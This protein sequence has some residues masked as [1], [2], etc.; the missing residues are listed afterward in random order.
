MKCSIF[1]C[2]QVKL[3]KYKRVESGYHEYYFILL[4]LQ[5]ILQKKMV[6][7]QN[8]EYLIEKQ[9][10]DKDIKSN[11]ERNPLHYACVQR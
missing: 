4:T 5:F 8:V 1:N 9:D 10:V 2:K 3:N 7:F 11:L 6:I